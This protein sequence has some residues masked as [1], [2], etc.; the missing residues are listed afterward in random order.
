MQPLLG[1]E[2]ILDHNLMVV[3][4]HL[5]NYGGGAL[6][7]RHAHRMPRIAVTEDAGPTS[8]RFPFHPGFHGRLGQLVENIRR[9]L[10]IAVLAIEFE[11]AI[12][13][14][15]WLR[16]ESGGQPEQ[17]HEKPKSGPQRA[18][19]LPEPPCL[20]GPSYTK[21]TLTTTPHSSRGLV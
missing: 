4:V 15:R 5:K 19:A 21:P 8:D 7:V 9:Q 10:D 12:G 1:A 20:G 6:Q 2:A 13:G 14:S 3:R 17:H 18:E 11:D 16:V